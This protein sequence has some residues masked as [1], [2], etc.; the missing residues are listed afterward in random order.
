MKCKV[1]VCGIRSLE[2]VAI[3]NEYPI[4]YVGFIFAPSKRR[5]RKEEARELIQLLR[6]DI[7]PVGV[8]VNE[9]IAKAVDICCYCGLSIAQLHGSE[10]QE[11]ISQM[12]IP[13]WKSIAIKDKESLNLIHQYPVVQGLLLDTYDEGRTGGTGKCFNWSFVKDINYDVQLILAGGLNPENIVEAV[14]NAQPDIVDVNSGVETHLR[15]DK[16]KI[17]ILIE[18]LKKNNLLI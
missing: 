13:V 4:H 17:Q 2:D 12:P 7:Q 11:Y 10:T 1:K 18:K 9:P 6:E 14:R 5:I 3:I 8:F 15:K 16:D